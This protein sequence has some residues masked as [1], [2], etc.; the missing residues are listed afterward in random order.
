MSHPS[1]LDDDVTLGQ[2]L[3]PE[4]AYEAGMA[5]ESWCAVESKK[6]QDW[7]RAERRHYK[8]QFTSTV[9]RDKRKEASAGSRSA[10]VAYSPAYREKRHYT[11]KCK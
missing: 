9:F 5:R 1:L 7:C 4:E 3:N 2:L 6:E 8:Q 10:W 11:T